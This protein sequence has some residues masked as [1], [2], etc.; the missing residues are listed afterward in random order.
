MGGGQTS[1]LSAA[2]GF[3]GIENSAGSG[4]KV[5]DGMRVA[6]RFSTFHPGFVAD[7]M[8]VGSYI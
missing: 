6:L 3:P 7:G 8:R 4:V 1:G 5:G 2:P